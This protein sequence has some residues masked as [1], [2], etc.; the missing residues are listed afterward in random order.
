MTNFPVEV[1]IL[2]AGGDAETGALVATAADEEGAGTDPLAAPPQLRPG[3]SG[4]V[5][6][7]TRTVP[8]AVVVPIQAVTI[9]DFN[10]L[11]R[12]AAE[13][14]DGEAEA[15]PPGEEDLRR[16]VFVVVDGQAVMREVQTGIQDD[17]HIEIISGLSAGDVV[18]S[19]PFRLLRTELDEGDAVEPR[20]PGAAPLDEE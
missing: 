11:R 4:T 3:M 13:E 8:N 12:E 19:G 17:T 16:V 10:A 2:G 6:V 18:V 9:R 15:P 20:D 7:F 5:D 14:D 1:R